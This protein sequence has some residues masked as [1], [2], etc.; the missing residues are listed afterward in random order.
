MIVLQ[1]I[2][3]ATIVFVAYAKLGYYHP[4][5]IVG[6]LR[7]YFAEKRKLQSDVLMV[8]RSGVPTGTLM[9]SRDNEALP[10]DLVFPKEMRVLREKYGGRIG[11][12]GKFAVI[13]NLQGKLVG[14]QLLASAVTEWSLT[15]DVSVA[16]MMVNPNHVG[17][18]RRYG[19]VELARTEG[20]KGLDKAPAVLMVLDYKMSSEIMRR[21]AEF[22]ENTDQN[23]VAA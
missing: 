8:T 4:L 11:Y 22:L 13:P 16:V 5:G 9:C 21:R 14:K 15:N 2:V 1:H 23:M 10:T 20:T 3:C 19:A 6:A 12:F 7:A 18:Y 17:L